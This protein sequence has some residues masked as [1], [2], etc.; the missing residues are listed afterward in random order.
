MQRGVHRLR[1]LAKGVPRR[2]L[3]CAS[4]RPPRAPSSSLPAPA[5]A[6]A[7]FAAASDALDDALAVGLPAS[8]AAGAFGSVSSLTSTAAVPRGG[9]TAFEPAAVHGF[10]GV[11]GGA[12]RLPGVNAWA[13]L[14]LSFGGMSIVSAAAF[15]HSSRILSHSNAT[16]AARDA[17]PS[18]PCTRQQ[19]TAVGSNRCAG[20][21][22]AAAIA[23]EAAFCV[24][25]ATAESELRSR[26]T[27][28]LPPAIASCGDS[29]MR[30]RLRSRNLA[31]SF[32]E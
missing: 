29:S 16:S 12:T 28:A 13:A 20:G 9:G 30:L 21:G 25:V 4:R 2:L 24:A 10:G 15:V 32:G 8:S 14:A 26:S 11:L 5:A 6:F 1:L 31:S 22:P 17:P 19:T 27:I 3:R 7:T 18:Q 23:E